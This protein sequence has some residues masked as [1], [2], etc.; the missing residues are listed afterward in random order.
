[1]KSRLEHPETKTHFHTEKKN[2]NIS[3]SEEYLTV[4]RQPMRSLDSTN[5][6]EK[7][8]EWA[9]CEFVHVGSGRKDLGKR[10]F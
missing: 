4:T 8:K 2:K 10:S 1:M 5:P 7:R 9:V 6:T 3:V